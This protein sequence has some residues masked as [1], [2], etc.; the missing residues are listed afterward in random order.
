MTEV[1]ESDIS[2]AAHDLFDKG[3]VAME[4]GNL[5]YAMD[6]FM[7]VLEMEPR[8]LKARKFLRAASVKRFVESGGGQMSHVIASV[9]AFPVFIRSLLSLRAGKADKALHTAEKLLR[10]DPLNLPFIRLMC[11]AAVAADMPEAAV[12]TLTVVREHYPENVEVLNWLGRLYTESDHLDEAKECFETIVN[13]RP[14]DTMAMKSLKDAM[15]RDS[16]A[17]GGW[18]EA[19]KEG[20]GSYRAVMKDAGE[21][22]V[23]EQ[24]G[25]EVKGEKSIELLVQESL[26]KLGQQPENTN[27]RRDLVN[28]YVK[29]NRFDDAIRTLEE[30]RQFTAAGDPALDQTMA[31]IQLGRFDYEIAVYREKGDTAGASAKEAEKQAFHLEDTQSRVKRY[32]NDLALRYDYGVLLFEKDQLNEAVQQFQIAQRHPKRHVQSLYYIGMCFK[33]KQQFDMAREQLEKAASECAEMDDLK[34]DIYYHLGE[35]L[36]AVGNYEQAVNQYYKE[37][38]QVDISY[39]DVA[40][41]IEKAYQQKPKG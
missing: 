36:E 19:G 24:K 34:K 6:M 41:K 35:I 4:R 3:L 14:H 10:K 5:L 32:P 22:A 23:L 15:A 12:Q 13:L 18:S 8:F 37:I 7:S 33:K 30:G 28:L 29:A 26:D 38:Y 9:S 25:K 2:K 21:A 1:I 11:R 27:Y 20:G 40:A 39:K 31:S 17:K 16:M